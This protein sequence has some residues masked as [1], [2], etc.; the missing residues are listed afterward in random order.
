[1]AKLR[2]IGVLGPLLQLTGRGPADAGDSSG[3][4]IDAMPLD[5]LVQAALHGG[6]SGP[7]LG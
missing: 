2:E 3:D 5:E 1:M 4:A 6:G 7:D